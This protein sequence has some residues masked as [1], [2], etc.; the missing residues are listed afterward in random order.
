MNAGR[1]RH[2][3]SVPHSF[4]FFFRRKGGKPRKLEVRAFHPCDK[5]KSQGWAR[6]MVGTRKSPVHRERS[7]GSAFG[8][9]LKPRAYRLPAPRF[10][11]SGRQ[12]AG[13]TD[14]RLGTLG[15]P[16]FGQ[17]GNPQA[18]KPALAASTPVWRQPCTAF[19]DRLAVPLQLRHSH[20]FFL[21][22]KKSDG[23]PA[24]RIDGFPALAAAKFRLSAT[25]FSEVSDALPCLQE[26]GIRKAV[27]SSWPSDG[28]QS[29]EARRDRVRAS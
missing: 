28:G 4:A 26:A 8:K 12:L 1:L 22:S 20:I 2:F 13:A 29:P 21:W 6:K 15:L 24:M 11:R 16:F 10:C 9:L 17:I 19:L 27:G 5:R 14:C 25:G 7:E 3:C 23:M 18:A